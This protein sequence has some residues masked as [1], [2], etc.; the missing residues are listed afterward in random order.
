MYFA[1][2][3]LKLALMIVY[4]LVMNSKRCKQA[5][6]RIYMANA[7]FRLFVKQKLPLN[8]FSKKHSVKKKEPQTSLWEY[9]NEGGGHGILKINTKGSDNKL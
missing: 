8:F 2:M 6:Q 5:K 3:S 4:F 7:T 1:L 9:F